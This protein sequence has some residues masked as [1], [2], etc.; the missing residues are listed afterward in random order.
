MRQDTHV[1]ALLRRYLPPGSTLAVLGEPPKPAIVA[2][3]LTGDGTKELA[4]GYMWSGHPY[5]MIVRRHNHAWHKAAT[6]EGSGYAIS[7]LNAARIT[8]TGKKDLIVGWQR[9]AIWSELSVFTFT[10]QGWRKVPG[11]LFYS[12]IEVEDMPGDEGKDG[13]SEIA[14]WEH[15]TGAAYKVKVYR[16]RNGKWVLALDVYPYYFKKVAAYYEQRVQEEPKAAFYRYYLADAQ[17]K[18]GLPEH[19]LL[20]IQAGLALSPVYPPP[21][22]WLALKKQA[23]EQLQRQIALY[24]ASIKQIGGTN[25]GYIDADGRFVLAPVYSHAQPFQANGLAVVEEK[26]KAGIING[27]GAFIVKPKYEYISPFSEGLAI[28][29]VK[30]GF[31]VIDEQGNVRTTKLYSYIAPFN[32]GRAVFQDSEFQYGYLD[33]AGKE[34]IP[35][36]YKEATDFHGGKAV[37]KVK[38]GQYALID[39]EGNTILSY[40]YA[41]VGNPGDGLL[42]FRQTE[43]GKYGYIDENGNVIIPPRY[44]GAQPFQEG[45]AVINLA[46]DYTNRYGLIDRTGTLLIAAQYNDMEPLGEGR[47]AVGVAVDSKKPFAGSLY[48]IYDTNGKQLTDFMY[49]SVMPYKQ[50]LASAHNAKETF[51]ID[52]SGHKAEGWPVVNGTGTLA[53]EGSLI[54]ADIDSRLSYID[55]TGKVIW[56]QN[57][58]IPLEGTYEVREEKCKPNKDYLVYYPQVTGLSEPGIQASINEKLKEQSG[59]KEINPAAQ[60]D[61]NYFGDFMVLF[62]RKQLL[63][64]KLFGYQYYFGAAHG[65]P[66][67][68]Y[69][70]IDLQTGQ[71]YELKD[72]FKKDSHYVKL[73]ST[74]IE[75]QIKTNPKYSYVWQDQYKGI[76]P[77][78]PFYV[79]E[80]ALYIYFAPYEIAAYAAGFPTFTIPY[81]EIMSSIDTGGAFWRSF[82]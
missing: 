31:A 24:P 58:V 72:L 28:V 34:V 52:K 40:P 42:A 78:Q 39:P 17:L 29:N 41:F 3:D 21:A 80:H 27:S 77:N 2:A 32:E 65:M 18:A 44:T 20:S 14:I 35:A 26:E 53:V 19:A 25:W 15:D 1:T 57:T 75:R 12:H 76:T 71:F 55:R 56:Q 67:E 63:V 70:H 8:D 47:V 54:R 73:L 51:F 6:L 79:G 7:Y 36:K 50:G 43:Q 5:V 16:Y 13:Q 46:A 68:I 74:I 11:D 59:I 60:L 37:V 10:G 61:Y 22:A 45:R 66:T 62:F 48:A 30:D 49:E 33:A 69:P 64:L 4:A 82:H 9:G 23:K 81:V 38:E